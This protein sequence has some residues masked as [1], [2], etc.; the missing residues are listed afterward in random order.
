MDYKMRIIVLIWTM[1]GAVKLPCANLLTDRV[2]KSR[3]ASCVRDIGVA[4]SNP[5]TPT[6]DF[7]FFL[8]QNTLGASSS[9]YRV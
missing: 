1:V 9:A 7:S 5:V 4:G 8:P 3:E 6:I 2:V